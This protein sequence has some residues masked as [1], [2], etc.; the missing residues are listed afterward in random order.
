MSEHILQVK[1]INKK[2]KRDGKYFDAVFDFSLNADFGE[3]IGI[4]GESGS[5]KSTVASMIA[6]LIQADSG[7]IQKRGRI[8]MIF[9]NPSG[10]LNPRMKVNDILVEGMKY[11]GK[12]KKEEMLSRAKEVLRLVGLDEGY[13]TRYPE[14]L[15]GGQ[16]QRIAIA[17]A[18]MVPPE[19]LICDEAT[20]ALDVSVQAQIMELLKLL[21]ENYGMTILFITHDLVLARKFCHRIIIMRNGH[22]VEEGFTEDVLG[23]PSS[24]YTRELLDAV[25]SIEDFERS[26]KLWQ[27]EKK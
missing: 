2:Y 13:L 23:N 26:E 22:L 21:H 11:Q 10:S 25:L 16:C 3:I 19:I 7:S 1:K 4:L 20:S 14:A 15:S 9:Q 24:T 12:Y 18:V 8:Q 6:G 27:Q 17:R 5:G